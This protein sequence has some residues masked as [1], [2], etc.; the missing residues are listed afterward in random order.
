MFDKK[1][2]RTTLKKQI[3]VLLVKASTNTRIKNNN[4]KKHDKGQKNKVKKIE[5]KVA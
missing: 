5:T 2:C 1:L 4:K 3:N